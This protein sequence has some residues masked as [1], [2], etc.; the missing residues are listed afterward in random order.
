MPVA[1]TVVH[2]SEPGGSWWSGGDERAAAC[3]QPERSALGAASG[4]V[5]RSGFRQS[6]GEVT[7]LHVAIQGDHTWIAGRSFA[8]M[9][10]VILEIFAV[11]WFD[12]LV[13]I[14][15]DG[16]SASLPPRSRA[17]GQSIEPPLL[18]QVQVTY[19]GGHAS[20]SFDGN[21]KFGAMD[22]TVIVG[23]AETL[24]AAVRTSD[25]RT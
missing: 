3:G 1:K 7:A 9:P 18:A 8:T 10:W 19:P 2:T 21:A 22:T 14:I 11:H 5:A 4:L 6:V 13:S 24:P 15:G 17:N 12:F 16:R 23:T 20:L 25:T